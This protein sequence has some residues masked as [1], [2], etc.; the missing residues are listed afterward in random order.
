[1][2]RSAALLGIVAILGLSAGTPATSSVIRLKMCHGGFADIPFGE[3]GKPAREKGCPFG[4][5][6]PLCQ[7]RKRRPAA[8][9][10]EDLD[11]RQ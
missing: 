7:E 5:H 11:A 2:T 3:N 8:A 1:M 4:C 9:G 10:P 6:A